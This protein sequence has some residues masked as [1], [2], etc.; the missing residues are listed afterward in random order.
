MSFDTEFRELNLLQELEKNPVISQRE[1]SNRFG[2]ALGATNACLRR[3]AQT[4]WL[5]VRGIKGKKVGYYITRKGLDEKARLETHYLSNKIRNY[6][7]LKG[8]FEK[9]FKEMERRGIRKIVFYGVSD[10][11][12][13][14]YMTL[15]RS[16]MELTGIVEDE[17]NWRPL[18]IFGL[19]L[20]RI[21][22]VGEMNPDG[23]FVTSLRNTIEPHLDRLK[24][25][26]GLGKKVI[27]LRL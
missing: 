17:E 11:M 26:N 15:Q 3:M 2:I 16:N 9:K 8:L 24:H 12:E 23:I 10:E 22:Q 21:E 19:E 1:L 13:V 7:E 27:L 6:V 5:T 18:K 14:A 20:K 4:G 25:L